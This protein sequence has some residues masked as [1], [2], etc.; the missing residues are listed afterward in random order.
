MLKKIGLLILV[1]FFIVT[2]N[3]CV[4]YGNYPKIDSVQIDDEYPDLKYTLSGTKGWGGGAKALEGILKQ[5]G[6]FKSVEK[7]TEREN[8]GLLINADVSAISPSIPAAAFGYLSYSTLT[9]LPFQS[10]Q[11]GYEIN[12]EVYNNGKR[13]KN[14]NYT[15]NRRTFIWMPMILFVWVNYLTPSEKD[16]FEA[17]TRQF[18]KDAEPLLE[19]IQPGNFARWDNFPGMY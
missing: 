14:Y 3:G 16:A 18:L 8:K 9:F 7:L 13:L 5:E 4:S 15:F 2:M 19:S 1:T 10:T 6:S 17:I 11:D 12:F